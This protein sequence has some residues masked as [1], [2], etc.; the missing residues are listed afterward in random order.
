MGGPSRSIRTARRLKVRS[1]RLPACGWAPEAAL[2]RCISLEETGRRAVAS[3]ATSGRRDLEETDS[4]R[5]PVGRKGLTDDPAARNR[6]PEAAVVAGTTIVAHHEVIVGRDRDWLRHVAGR[7]GAAA[8]GIDEGLPRH[9]AVDNRM[10][11]LDVEAVAGA[12]DDSLDEIG[13]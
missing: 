5:R 6:S 8:A 10:A 1:V 11:V 9:H 4:I 2:S 7:P 12:G 13:S 3:R